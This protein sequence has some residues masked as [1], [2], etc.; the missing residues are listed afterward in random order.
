MPDGIRYCENMLE[1]LYIASDVRRKDPDKIVIALIDEFPTFLSQLKSTT[2]EGSVLQSVL[3]IPR[4][5]F[6]NIIGIGPVHGHFIRSFRVMS[7][8]KIVKSL[9]GVID[10]RRKGH[11]AKD[12][13]P[14][15]VENTLFISARLKHGIV[16]EWLEVG[17]CPWTDYDI[18]NGR[19]PPVGQ[20][21]YETYHIAEFS[22]SPTFLKIYPR[23]ISILNAGDVSTFDQ[24]G[25]AKSMYEF[26][27]QYVGPDGLKGDKETSEKN[28]NLE[29]KAAEF[30]IKHRDNVDY[31]QG[32][33][34]GER[35]RRKIEFSD[36]FKARILGTSIGKFYRFR[37]KYC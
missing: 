23:M 4:K 33:P 36:S 27:S 16:N 25:V 26:L 8:W 28:E 3:H 22:M 14:L 7:T 5:L 21:V 34:K 15:T 1:L 35:D 19:Y 18:E 29:E 17:S 12:G 2:E 20:R 10:L 30:L 31:I 24:K 11:T 9:Q 32:V 37:E 6:I 13:S